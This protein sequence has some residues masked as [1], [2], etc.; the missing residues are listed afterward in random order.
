MCGVTLEDWEESAMGVMG[1]GGFFGVVVVVR[2]E[3]GGQGIFG[4]YTWTLS[5][6]YLRY[7]ERVR[8]GA[9]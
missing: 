6:H 2:F 1:G 3:K 7:H 4:V 5:F 8:G 9:G